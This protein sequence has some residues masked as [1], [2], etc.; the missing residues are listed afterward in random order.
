MKTT[1][2]ITAILLMLLTPLAAQE[3]LPQVADIQRAYDSLKFEEAE[4]LAN[5]ALA[6]AEAYSPADLV[7]IHLLAAYL[8]FAQKRSAAARQ[9]FESALSLQP[10][11]TLDSLLVSPR[12]VRLFEQV[13]NEYRVGLVSGAPTVKYIVVQDQRLAGLRRSLVLPGWGQRHLGRPVAG[14]IYTTGFLVALGAGVGLQVLQ[15]QAHDRYRNAAT[16]ADIAAAY[17][18]FNRRYWL[19]NAVFASAAGIYAV[20][21]LDLLLVSPI[22][23]AVAVSSVGANSLKISFQVPLPTLR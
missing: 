10:S 6:H 9:H 1:P 11:L 23:P 15:E 20:N 13:K 3:T 5:Q 7:Q 14:W 12:I 17:D 19:R 16:P 8:G 21:V 2:L 22:P 4:A 18:R